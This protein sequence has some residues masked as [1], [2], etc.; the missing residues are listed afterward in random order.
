MNGEV[1]LILLFRMVIYEHGKLIDRL[2]VVEVAKTKP[3]F[4]H[5]RPTVRCLILEFF[6]THKL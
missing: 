6:G 2:F 4:R 1:N 3:L 5:S